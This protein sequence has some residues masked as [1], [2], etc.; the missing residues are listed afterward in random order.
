MANNNK[1]KLIH[2]KEAIWTTLLYSDIFSFPLSKDELWNFLITQKKIARNEF[3]ESLQKIE[4]DIV[5]I[6]GYYCLHKREEIIAQRIKNISEVKKKLQQARF[7]AKRLAIIP[8]ILFIGIS[9]G[10]A[11]NNVTKEDDID[12]VIIVKKNTLFVSRISLLV[13]LEILGVRRY[14]NQKNTADTICVNLLFDE[15]ALIWPKDKRNVYT[16]REIVQMMPLFER[17]NLY[18]RFFSANAWAQKYFPNKKILKKN[19]ISK[20]NSFFDRIIFLFLMNS[21]VEFIF[22]NI[23]MSLMRKHQ[24]KEIVTKHFL[25]LLPNDY[26]IEIL[27]QLRLKMRQFGLLTKY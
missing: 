25:A 8:S 10:L 18:Q 27:R 15:T 7:I 13:I 6:N 17:K 14:R 23:Q 2:V 3:E 5:F 4:K 12:F 24:T 1:V 19:F 16:A 22:R 21:F 26:R 20:E 9:G 11:A